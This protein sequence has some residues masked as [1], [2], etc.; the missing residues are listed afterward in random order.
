MNETGKNIV[1]EI[2]RATKGS[3]YGSYLSIAQ[4]KNCIKKHH[5]SVAAVF[6]Q[7]LDK[8]YAYYSKSGKAITLT[9]AFLDS[10]SP[11]TCSSWQEC[12]KFI[13][14]K[15]DDAV[16]DYGKISNRDWVLKYALDP[17][18]VQECHESTSKN[19]D[20]DILANN[21]SRLDEIYRNVYYIH[22]SKIEEDQKAFEQRSQELKEKMD[23]ENQIKLDKESKLSSFEKYC[24]CF[25]EYMQRD[26]YDGG[27]LLESFEKELQRNLI[28]YFKTLKE[29]KAFSEFISSHYYED[30]NEYD[31]FNQDYTVDYYTYK[32]T[33]CG[34]TMGNEKGILKIYK[35][36]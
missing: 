12:L 22:S 5:S 17:I 28:R 36:E 31:N 30:S 14:L 18:A 24:V 26:E 34:K 23:K 2:N 4:F 25:S 8:K 35:G 29:A 11:Y 21:K 6:Q 13:E 16:R 7:M 10:F 19:T 3:K 32:V 33:Y 9:T 20:A 1:K 27:Y 15:A